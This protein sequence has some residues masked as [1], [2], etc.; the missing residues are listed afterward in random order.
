[1]PNVFRFGGV[2]YLFADVLGVIPNAF[3]VASDKKQVQQIGNPIGL[4][5]H[6]FGK[7]IRNRL[8]QMIDLTISFPQTT[9]QGDVVI[10]KSSDAIA[11]QSIRFQKERAQGDSIV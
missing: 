9:S 8:I 10:G 3:E 6:S 4:L 5:G 1:M 11:K 2:N 7:V